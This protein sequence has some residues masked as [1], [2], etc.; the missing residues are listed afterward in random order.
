M[1]YS[2]N[3]NQV[4]YLNIGLMVLSAGLAFLF[5]FELFLVVY[6]VLGPL[7]YLTEISWLHDKNYFTQG[8]RDYLFLLGITIIITV[9]YF[10]WV[11]APQGTIE[12]FTGLAFLGALFLVILRSG[13]ARLVA[14]LAAALVLFFFAASEPFRV[15][16]GLFLPTL[17]HVFLFTAMFILVG[18]LRGRSLSGMASLAVFAGLTLSFFF[19]HPAHSAYHVSQYVRDNYGY[20]KDNGAGSSPFILVNFYI[21]KILGLND[22]GQG[23]VPLLDFVKNAN[24]FLYQNPTALALMSFIAFSY[25]YHYLNWFS[26]TSIIGWHDIPRSRAFAILALWGLSLGI[27]AYNYFL[28]L[29]WLFFLSFTHV[30]LEFPLNQLTLIGIAKE[31]RKIFATRGATA[32]AKR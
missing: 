10:G 20:F 31:T 26:K 3:S 29:Q 17:I 8:R 15:V 32:E 30:F 16:F 19:Y 5:P 21:T 6:A 28:G 2:L 13:T 25:T 12:F 24:G 14:F 18:A 4:N 22:F 1:S 7:H 23:K 9:L 27:Y 11:P